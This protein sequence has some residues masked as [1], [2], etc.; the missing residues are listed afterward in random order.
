MIH[1]A[2]TSS[3]PTSHP[4][5]YNTKT[6]QCQYAVLTASFVTFSKARRLKD[7]LSLLFQTAIDVPLE[8]W[9]E[10]VPSLFISRT[11]KRRKNEGK[12]ERNALSIPT[13]STLQS[14]ATLSH[15]NGYSNPH[16]LQAYVGTILLCCIFDN[17][18]HTSF[19]KIYYQCLVQEICHCHSINIKQFIFILT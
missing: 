17:E 9:N 4:S 1:C 5:L 6:R 16:N 11:K 15:L 7:F 2:V 10:S 19:K 14:V 18:A 8:P 3:V 12:Y 13:S